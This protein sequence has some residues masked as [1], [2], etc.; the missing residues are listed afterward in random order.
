MPNWNPVYCK[1]GTQPAMIHI[2]GR[3]R[4]KVGAKVKYKTDKW[5]RYSSAIVDCIM[6]LRLS[7]W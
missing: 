4:I 5:G 2:D 6:P 7:K 1:L 3:T